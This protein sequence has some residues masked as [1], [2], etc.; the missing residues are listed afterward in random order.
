MLNPK[1]D[2]CGPGAPWIT[3]LR[4]TLALLHQGDIHFPCLPTYT[5]CSEPFAV[6]ALSMPL[7]LPLFPLSL[8]DLCSPS[9]PSS[10]LPHLSIPASFLCE[11][12]G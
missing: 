9:M 11:Q 4:E 1:E 12:K 3:L 2:I 7:C 6:H 5:H 8:T 10:F